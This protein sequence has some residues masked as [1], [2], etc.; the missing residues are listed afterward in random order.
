MQASGACRSRSACM[1]Q[2]SW[3][4]RP[5]SDLIEEWEFFYG[6]AR[7]LQ[8]QLKMYYFE[9]LTSHATRVAGTGRHRHGSQADDR[10]AL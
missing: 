7:Y 8:L 5:G 9:T 10:R 3:I 6:V 4:R 2:D 1:R